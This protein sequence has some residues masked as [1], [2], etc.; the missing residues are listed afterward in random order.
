VVRKAIGQVTAETQERINAIRAA[1][2]TNA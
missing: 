1:N 2:E